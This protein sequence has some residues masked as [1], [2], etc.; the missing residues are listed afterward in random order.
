MERLLLP[1]ERIVLRIGQNGVR[2]GQLIF[3]AVLGVLIAPFTFGISLVL[4]IVVVAQL[5]GVKRAV[6]NYRIIEQRGGLFGRRLQEVALRDIQ[7]VEIN[8]SPLRWG[9]IRIFSSGGRKV[10]LDY[11]HA[12]EQVKATI[13]QLRLVGGASQTPAGPEAGLQAS[14]QRVQHRANYRVLIAS[15]A[16]GVLAIALVALF[17]SPSPRVQ[18]ARDAPTPEPTAYRVGEIDSVTGEAWPE[19]P[20]PVREAQIAVY[21]E[22]MMP[23]PTDALVASIFDQMLFDCVDN[24]LRSVRSDTLRAASEACASRLQERANQ[25]VRTYRLLASDR[26]AWRAATQ[27]DRLQAAIT[28][29]LAYR[30]HLP[31]GRMADLTA[32]DLSGCMDRFSRDV[33]SINAA[34]EICVNPATMAQWRVVPHA[35]RAAHTIEYADAF[36]RIAGRGQAD[37]QAVRSLFDCMAEA[38]TPEI[39]TSSPSE[40]AAACA[41]LLGWGR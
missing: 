5:F 32:T 19:I 31:P 28:F 4:S 23:E 26:L 14:R 12:P 34:A 20:Q 29:L 21:A 2:T 8:R 24:T 27:D 41:A 37:A 6:T 3:F 13:D 33:D 16:A 25:V 36:Y 38:Y 18:P 11:V 15:L 40:I 10:A 39:D 30:E 9:T 1:D 22:T 35:V 7:A 17:G